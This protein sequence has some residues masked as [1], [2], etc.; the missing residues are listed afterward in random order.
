MAWSCHGGIRRFRRYLEVQLAHAVEQ[1]LP[2]VVVD[3]D[4][5]ARVVSHLI[6]P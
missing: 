6:S 1:R 5:K 3:R 4:A 2:R